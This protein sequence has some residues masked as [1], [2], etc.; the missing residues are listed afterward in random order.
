M[1]ALRRPRLGPIVAVAAATSVAM[2]W[3]QAWNVARNDYSTEARLPLA[4]LLHGH[5]LRFL[6]TAPPYGASLALRAPFALVASLAHGSPLLIYRLAALPCV[7]ALAGL[8]AW[9]APRVR[10]GGGGWIAVALTVVVCVANPV[11]Y[12]ALRIGHP[13]EALGAVLC[14]AAVLCAIRG[15][16]TWAGVLLGAAIANKQWAVVAIGPMLIALPERRWYALL[17]AGAVA[18][19]MLAPFVLTSQTVSVASVRLTVNDTGSV[20][21]AQQIWWFF[22][23]HGH[24]VH[25]MLGQIPHGYRVPPAWLAGR[26]HLLIAWIG[27]PLTLL[28]AH[29]TMRREDALLLLALLLLLRCMLDPWDLVY[30]PLPFIVALLAWE[31]TVKHRAPLGALI[32]SAATW[33]I[34]EYLPLRSNGLSLDADAVA[35]IVPSLAA[36]VLIARGVY[37]RQ[38]ASR[39]RSRAVLTTLAWRRA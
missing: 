18:G 14:V 5:L 13:E 38:G 1:S 34:F 26:A 23:P 8:A 27:L 19:A 22:A 3:V 39:E 7:L 36:V 17:I 4:A 35:F 33:L 29:R 11:T 32:A 30:Y 2:V 21:Y 25:S 9:I 20:F 12:Y 16:A 15:H 24:W 6:E 31:T 28:A 10:G 37:G